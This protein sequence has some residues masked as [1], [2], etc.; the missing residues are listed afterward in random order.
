MPIVR[1]A[2]FI[3]LCVF[4]VCARAESL[5]DSARHMRVD[6]VKPGMKGYGLSVFSGTQ[7]VR[8]GVEV[9]SVLENFNPQHHVILV[10]L[11]GQN[12]EHTGA[13]QGMSG[14]PIYLRDASGRDRM[15]GAFAYGFPLAKDAIGGVQPIEY[16]LDLPHERKPVDQ[17]NLGTSG[18]GGGMAAGYSVINAI[19][20]ARARWLRPESLQKQSVNTT[21]LQQLTTPISVSGLDARTISDLNEVFADRNIQLLQ[22]GGGRAA[23]TGPTTATIAPGAVLAAPILTGDVNLTATGTVT[24]VL[25]GVV[26]GFGHPFNNE[27]PITLPFGAGRIDGII[28]TLT[29]SYKLGSL[30][31]L[32]GTLTNDQ[33]FAIVGQMG[34]VPATIPIDITVKYADGSI[35]RSYHFDCASHPGFTPMVS[36]IAMLS[37]LTATR[38]IPEHHTLDYQIAI[39]FPEGRSIKTAN[40][41]SNPGPRMLAMEIAAP[42]SVA[43]E[44]PF[45]RI[46]PTRIKATVTVDPVDHSAE[47]LSIRLDRLKYAPGETVKGFVHY[48]R[49][50]GGEETYPIEYTLPADL[51][52]GQYQFIVSDLQ[53]YFGDE[54]AMNAW[55]FR[56]DRTDDLFTTLNE[57][58]KLR[59]DA[60]Y[61]RLLQPPNGVA[62]RRGAMPK[63]P[64]SKRGILLGSGRNDVVPLVPDGL[65]VA[66]T[67]LIFSGAT[68]FAITVETH[69]ARPAAVP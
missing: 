11:S 46:L 16:M 49:Y 64:A 19:N 35:N 65:K 30:T 61:L 25:N 52:D 50:Q 2:V 10:R 23:T 63:M 33:A 1:A 17:T 3:F 21:Q 60:L 69:P 38:E 7:I 14:S 9:V 6:E 4:S 57:L 40:R 42:M 22:S 27:G 12:L 43:A 45:K 32:S 36:P 18:G 48:R 5:F 41:M 44:N 28:A 37:A 39:D 55:R 58:G 56:A 67:K 20:E 68:D 47:I 24:E 53:R 51:K 66:P 54:T 34:E 29:S 8:F 62:I 31:A 15:V 13:I 26:F 59:Y